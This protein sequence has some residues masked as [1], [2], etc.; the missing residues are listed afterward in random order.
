MR[1]SWHRW[2]TWGLRRGVLA[3]LSAVCLCGGACGGEGGESPGGAAQSALSQRT[4]VGRSGPDLGL[5]TPDAEQTELPDVPCACPVPDEALEPGEF[6]LG[7]GV[8]DEADELLG[9]APGQE[10]EIVQGPQ[11]GVHVE[12]GFTLALPAEW[13]AGFTRVTVSAV[14]FE[15]E[16]YDAEWVGSFASQKYLVVESEPGSRTYL[17]G[18]IPVIFDQNLAEYYQDAWCCVT[19]EVGAYGVGAAQSEVVMKSR[20]QH[21][22]WCVDRE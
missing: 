18:M 3:V 5:P 8:F 14:S 19:L 9:V 13:P 15:P 20:V 6:P 11:G 21:T 2:R 1:G 10:I 16:L 12:V 17:S 4:D 22:F 7:M